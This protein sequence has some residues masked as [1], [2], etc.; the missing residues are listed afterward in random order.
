MK[1]S[2]NYFIKYGEMGYYA[3][4]ENAFMKQKHR[5]MWERRHG[6]VGTGMKKEAGE[7]E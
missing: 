6:P 4:V 5:V 2:E 7:E 1:A 3:R